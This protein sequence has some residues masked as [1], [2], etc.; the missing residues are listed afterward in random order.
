MSSSVVHCEVFVITQ[1]EQGL[2]LNPQTN[3]SSTSFLQEQLNFT[4]SWSKTDVWFE[5]PRI[6][7]QLS[8]MKC[9]IFQPLLLLCWCCGSGRLPSISSWCVSQAFTRDT[10][11]GESKAIGPVRHPAK[12]IV[13]YSIPLKREPI[14]ITAACPKHYRLLHH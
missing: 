1:E 3:C 12:L 5:N 8:L 9:Y 13:R 4:F 2:V 10:A 14:T 7:T 6:V 11:R